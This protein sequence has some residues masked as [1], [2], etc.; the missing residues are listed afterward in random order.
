[1]NVCLCSKLCSKVYFLSVKKKKNYLKNLQLEENTRN[2]KTLD[3][4]QAIQDENL[5]SKIIHLIKYLFIIKMML[6]HC[7]CSSSF[8]SHQNLTVYFHKKILSVQVQ[9][10]TS[11][12]NPKQPLISRSESFFLQHGFCSSS[13]RS[14]CALF[15]CL[16]PVSIL[17]LNCLVLKSPL[18]AL[19][20]VCLGGC[21][22]SS[23]H[24]RD[25]GV[26]A[27]SVIMFVNNPTHVQHSRSDSLYHNTAD[28]GPDAI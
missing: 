18:S 26:G 28:V 5:A 14:A 2:H 23:L 10:K 20:K 21:Q 9:C 3:M 8:C 24:C 1:M 22:V 6:S 13:Q 19:Q 11:L 12:L 25:L 4:E 27:I 16:L 7:Y 17:T 15:P